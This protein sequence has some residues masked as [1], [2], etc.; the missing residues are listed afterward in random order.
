MKERKTVDLIEALSHPEVAGRLEQLS[1]RQPRAW[2][3]S[4]RDHGQLRTEY[5]SVLDAVKTVLLA[6]S[7]LRVVEV[8]ALVEEHLNRIVPKSSVK[9]ALARNARGPDSAFIRV[10]QGRYRRS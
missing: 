7:P 9:N 2:T 5:S 4:R 3:R 10:A 8:H 1:L 6:G